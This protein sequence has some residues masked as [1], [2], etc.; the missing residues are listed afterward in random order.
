MTR[1]IDPATIPTPRLDAYRYRLE[2]ERA[3]REGRHSDAALL[4]T[5]E[6]DARRDVNQRIDR[7]REALR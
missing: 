1:I 7:I 2:A 4:R 5:L 6:A 3:E